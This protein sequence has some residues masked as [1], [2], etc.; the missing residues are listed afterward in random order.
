MD[1]L[2]LIIVI[3]VIVNLIS[4]FTSRDTP[5]YCD[6]TCQMQRDN[7]SDMSADD[8]LRYRGW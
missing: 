1:K 2:I 8:N 6:A 4:S 5:S 3:L 7:A